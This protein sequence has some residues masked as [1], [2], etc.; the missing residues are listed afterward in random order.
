MIADLIRDYA[1]TEKRVAEC[2]EEYT[3][4]GIDAAMRLA[5]TKK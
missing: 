5:G 2:A 1:Y 3:R 4:N